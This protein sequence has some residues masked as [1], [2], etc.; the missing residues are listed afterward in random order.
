MSLPRSIQPYDFEENPVDWDSPFWTVFRTLI[1]VVV[2]SVKF[3]YIK[4]EDSAMPKPACSCFY[5]GFIILDFDWQHTL[6][7]KRNIED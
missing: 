7:F 6:D 4:F 2:K 3:C 5:Q 1:L